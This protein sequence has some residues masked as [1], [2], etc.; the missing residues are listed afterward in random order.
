MA[1]PDDLHEDEHDLFE[2]RF[3]A[4]ERAH[5]LLAERVSFLEA[6][7]DARAGVRR[8]RTVIWLIVGELVLGLAALALAALQVYDMVGAHLHG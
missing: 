6:A 5:D 4:S 3:E 2:R 8:E 1:D 7:R